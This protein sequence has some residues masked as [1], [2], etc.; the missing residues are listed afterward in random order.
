M[1]CT[2]KNVPY[3]VAASVKESLSGSWALQSHI[4]H[5]VTADRSVAGAN[6]VL[7]VVVVQVVAVFAR[8]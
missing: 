7:V 1:P 3:L 4:C 8:P 5:I 6:V 2:T